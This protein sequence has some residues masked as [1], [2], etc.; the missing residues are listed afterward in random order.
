VRFVF[1]QNKE[2]ILKNAEQA[3]LKIFV[4]G[5]RGFPDIQGG[6][7]KH[8]EILYPLIASE[9]FSITV[10]RRRPYVI[11][12]E[13]T[14]SNIR[15]I[16]L[17]STRIQGFEAFYHT[18]LCAMRCIFMRPDIVHIHNIGPGMFIPL[19][20]LAG[21]KVVMT[22]HSPNYEHKKWSLFSRIFLKFAE[23]LSLRFSDCVIFVSLYQKDKSG[24]NK[25]FIH[26]NNGV[27]IPAPVRSD[28]YIRSL[29]LQKQSYLL[30]VGRLVEEKGFDLLIRAYAR[31][32]QRNFQLVIAGDADH[33]TD[34][35]GLIKKLAL[36][37]GVVMTGYVTG[38]NLQELFTNA[39][40]FVLPSYNEGLPISILEAMSYR[41]PMLVSDIPANKQIALKENQFFLTGSEESLVDK[42]NQQLKCDFEPMIY[43]MDPYDWDRIASQTQSVYEQVINSGVLKS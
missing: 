25:K 24:D 13:K 2:N 33:E 10:F 40:L 36:E 8:C 35:S 34:Y 1:K 4:A 20:K 29:G 37:N 38:T 15:F 19:L 16:D 14:F 11:F 17:P 18:F 28:N 3:R 41:L 5:T 12:K 6:V 7:E 21:L 32:D 31:L 26:I 23:Y 9:R 27:Q 42:L 22:Y 30:A 43:N 39:R